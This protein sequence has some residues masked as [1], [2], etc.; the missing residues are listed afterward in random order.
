MLP[1]PVAED[2]IKR[3][4]DQIKHIWLL[5]TDPAAVVPVFSALLQ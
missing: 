5:F 4:Y 2:A 3:P 1:L